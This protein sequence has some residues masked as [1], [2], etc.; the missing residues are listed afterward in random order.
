MSL[1]SH[2]A[3]L[4][5]PPTGGYEI[6]TT[7]DRACY[8]HLPTMEIMQRLYSM[9]PHGLP[10]LGLVL[11]RMGIV[12]QLLTNLGPS[13]S[14]FRIVMTGALV[15]SM[16]LGMFTSVACA[17]LLAFLVIVTFESDGISVARICEGLNLLSLALLGP[18]AYSMDARLF[19][20]RM[21]ELRKP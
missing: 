12:L 4:R 17:W 7:A 9:F 1:I 2:I 15:V 6:P 11:L 3:A 16:S 8:R 21:L 14:M 19:G 13:P 10:G 5:I 20:R 18:G